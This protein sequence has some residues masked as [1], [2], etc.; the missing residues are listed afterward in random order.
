MG[1]ITTALVKDV[2]HGNGLDRR[3]CWGGSGRGRV[4][5]HVVGE[6]G[7]QVDHTPVLALGDL[8]DKRVAIP[9]G[10]VRDVDP[11]DNVVEGA[12]G[13]HDLV[14]NERAER[15]IVSDGL[16]KLCELCGGLR[17]VKALVGVV[18]HDFDVLDTSHGRPQSAKVEP[19]V[20]DHDNGGGKEKDPSAFGEEVREDKE[21]GES[22]AKR[23]RDCRGAFGVRSMERLVDGSSGG[24]G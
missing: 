14:A 10:L 5:Q 6:V 11:I 9:V 23:W 21:L 19:G 1:G 2:L 4:R 17:V 22:L 15:R 24:G 18:E 7:R 16:E 3:D 8:V 20:D 13:I 12:F